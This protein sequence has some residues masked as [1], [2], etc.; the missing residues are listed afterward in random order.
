M[1]SKKSMLKNGLGELLLEG[2]KSSSRF[3]DLFCGGC[4]VAWFIGE[5]TSLPVIATDIQNYA[6][7]LAK[8]ILLRTSAADS[9]LIANEWIEKAAIHLSRN[10]I[11]DA[12]LKLKH[13]ESVSEYAQAA[14]RLC[15]DRKL[16]VGPIWAAYGGHYF[17]PLQALTI[18]Y[19]IKY[20]PSDEETRSLCLAS[21]LDAVSKCVASPGHTAQPFKPNNTAGKY[22]MEA[23]ARDP[24]EESRK[25]LNDLC[26]RHALMRG[27]SFVAD[28]VTEAAKL[29][30]GDLVFVDPPYSGV[31]YSR[32]YH[33]FESIVTGYCGEVS[34]TGRYP[35]LQL[36][37]QSHFSNVGQSGTALSNL[38]ENLA[39]SK[40]RVLFTFP[41]GECSNGLSGDDVVRISKKY[42]KI[43]KEMIKG[44]F[45]TLGGNN[46][47]REA[48]Q[49]S[50]ELVILMHPK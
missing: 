34:G 11:W 43:D 17:S 21:L 8:S 12:L 25:A 19:L 22:L 10:Q 47:N 44:R 14:R 32:F 13:T 16:R 27:E 29:H 39:A 50:Q 4:S 33:V 49:G 26:N 9:N 6:V 41:K 24:L 38:L 36:R 3:V 23:W 46:K 15:R 30:E 48:R 1:G 5:R 35:A 31:Q 37:P 45:S 18:D 28:A 42:F 20:L 2:S 7:V 40:C